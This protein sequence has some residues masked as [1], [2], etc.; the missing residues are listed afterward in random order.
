[1]AG[2]VVGKAAHLE[3]GLPEVEVEGA[4][5]EAADVRLRVRVSGGRVSVERL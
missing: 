2:E 3:E 1:M 4:A 5:A